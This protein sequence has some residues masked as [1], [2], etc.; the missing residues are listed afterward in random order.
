MLRDGVE[1]AVVVQQRMAAFDTKRRDNQI[2]GLA[3]GDPAPTQEL[4]VARD[5]DRKLGV[6]DGRDVKR[7]QSLF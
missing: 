3:N 4:K 2:G 5:D 7:P 1:I 6:K